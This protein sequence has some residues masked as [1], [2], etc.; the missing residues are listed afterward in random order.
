MSKKYF[1][2]FQF[3]GKLVCFGQMK[4]LQPEPPHSWQVHI[5]QVVTEEQLVTKSRELESAL[6]NEQY[7]EFCNSKIS[8]SN[9]AHE[10]LLWQFLAANFEP[11]P[12]SEFL[13]LLGFNKEEL[14][15][16]LSVMLDTNSNDGDGDLPKVTTK[17]SQ[18]GRS[19]SSLLF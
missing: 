15:K 18:L 19:V 5:S 11:S 16:K 10:K 12:R 17:L 14:T 9:S 3:G 8:E 13:N 6:Q 7:I 1:F 4:N 2:L